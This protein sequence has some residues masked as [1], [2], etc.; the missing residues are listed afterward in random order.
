MNDRAGVVRAFEEGR[1]QQ[2]CELF[3]NNMQPR[4][5]K[6]FCRIVGWIRDYIWRFPHGFQ[7]VESRL[8]ITTVI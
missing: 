8:T 5:Y 6:T 4:G 2:Q 7:S 3:L 1:L